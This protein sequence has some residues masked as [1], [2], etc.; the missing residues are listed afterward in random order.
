M[1]RRLVFL[2]TGEHGAT[3]TAPS[4]PAESPDQKRHHRDR[5]LVVKIDEK[6][7]QPVAGALEQVQKLLEIR[8]R[9]TEHLDSLRAAKAGKS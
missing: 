6:T 1:R 8:Q 9:A 4:Y 3:R 2:K 7:G 5:G